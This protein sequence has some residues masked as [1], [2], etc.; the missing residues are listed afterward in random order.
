MLSFTAVSPVPAGEL[1]DDDVGRIADDLAADPV[2]GSRVISE[3]G[4][5][6]AVYIPL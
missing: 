5:G 3:D 4:T 6:L 1:S 2:L